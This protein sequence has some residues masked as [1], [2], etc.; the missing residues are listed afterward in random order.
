MQQI[1]GG[2]TPDEATNRADTAILGLRLLEGIDEAA[3]EARYGVTLDAE[4]GPA[5]ERHLA[6]GLIERA[7]GRVRLTERGLLLSNE[8]FIDLLP[9]P[10]DG[11]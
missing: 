2:E 7:D 1:A 9:D 3:F 10:D 6:L 11:D 8:V 5:L 4:F